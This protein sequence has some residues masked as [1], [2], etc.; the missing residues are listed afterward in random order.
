MAWARELAV[1]GSD[2]TL[3][4]AVCPFLGADKFPMT[5]PTRKERPAV[6]EIKLNPENKAKVASESL[7]GSTRLT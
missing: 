3:Q 5:F 6:E 1:P 4:A 7:F 2:H